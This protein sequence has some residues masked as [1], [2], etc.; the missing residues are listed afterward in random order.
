MSPYFFFSKDSTSSFLYFCINNCDCEIDFVRK[1]ITNQL[2]NILYYNNQLS[3]IIN[4]CNKTQEGN[5]IIIILLIV[6]YI[7][8]YL[9]DSHTILLRG[10]GKLL[11]MNLIKFDNDNV[12][13]YLKQYISN[14]NDCI[15]IL[16]WCYLH[17][18]KNDLLYQY[19]TPYILT[20]LCYV[21]NS[22][23][24]TLLSLVILHNPILFSNI[25]NLFIKY[26]YYIIEIIQ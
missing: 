20:Y 15:E 11:Y 13:N 7:L 12:Q 25:I 17:C 26:I 18:S 16:I 10:Y 6:N 3:L 8:K 1:S 21:I 14:D 2:T 23:S 24:I 5:S 4:I 19:L 9:L 22:I